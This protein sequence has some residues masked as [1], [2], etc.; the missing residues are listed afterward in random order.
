[1][2]VHRAPLTDHGD[3]SQHETYVCWSRMQ[4]EAGQTLDTIVRR[5]EYERQAGD[6]LFFWGVGNAPATAISALAR[7]SIPVPV[8][9]S[10]MK[11]RPKAID[12]L[13]SRTVVWRKYIDQFGKE[14]T[15]P[16]SALVTSRGDSASGPKVKHY[17]L[18][19]RSEKPLCLQRGEPFDPRAFRNVGKVGGPV[20]ASQVTALLR[21][22][23]RPSANTDYEVNLS[24]WL[25]GGYWVRLTDPVEIPPSVN[26]EIATFSGSPDDWLQLT[27]HVKHH[28][29]S[30]PHTLE[31]ML[32]LF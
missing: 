6:G 16:A 12:T 10:V 31:T 19:C 5:K 30:Q 8:I 21:Q 26:A 13:P 24:A 20:G 7:L 3:C 17:A 18:V 1:M 27:R 22:V 28:A 9:F 2:V 11:S 4:T 32:Q 14:R 15:L 23:D 29:S 25:T